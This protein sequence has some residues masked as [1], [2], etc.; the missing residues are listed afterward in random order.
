[1]PCRRHSQCRVWGESHQEGRVGATVGAAGLGMELGWGLIS[2]GL[3]SQAEAA[4][5]MSEIKGSHMAEFDV[6]G[7]RQQLQRH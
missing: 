6:L 4:A 1:M 5:L 3:C 7:L 2:P